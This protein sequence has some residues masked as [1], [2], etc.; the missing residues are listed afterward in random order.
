MDNQ[1]ECGS[2]QC[3]TIWASLTSKTR[4]E[5][6][7][8]GNGK[9]PLCRWFAHQN[10]HFLAIPCEPR[11]IT[12]EVSTTVVVWIWQLLT[13]SNWMRGSVSSGGKIKLV[14]TASRGQLRSWLSHLYIHYIY[15]YH[16]IWISSISIFDKTLHPSLLNP[17]LVAP[18]VFLLH[19]EL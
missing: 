4:K 2:Q 16:L 6:G 15:I 8:P 10:L 5:H 14:T 12:L 9:S 19:P 1:K 7:D 11:L 18:N 17:L 13:T 3:L